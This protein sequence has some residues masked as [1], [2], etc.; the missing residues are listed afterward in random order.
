MSIILPSARMGIAQPIG[1]LRTPEG[2]PGIEVVAID[3]Q[4][5]LHFWRHRPNASGRTVSEKH[6]TVEMPA[7]SAAAF[8]EL[9]QQA[10]SKADR[11]GESPMP[12]RHKA[13]A[14]HR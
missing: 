6:Y 1:A 5:V 3:H 4:V 13:T 12:K 14:L 8:A 9:L 2:R 7:A 11:V 10:S